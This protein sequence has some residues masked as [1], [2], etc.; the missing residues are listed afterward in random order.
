MD[1]FESNDM[2]DNR[3]DIRSLM[4]TIGLVW[5]HSRYFHTLSNMTLFFNLFHN[6]V[7]ECVIRTVEP[8]S[9]FQ[10]DVDE[11]YKKVDTNIRHLDYYK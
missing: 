1:K 8:D 3:Q 9:I 11:A 7:I 2:D 6:S 4:L 5:G 10:G